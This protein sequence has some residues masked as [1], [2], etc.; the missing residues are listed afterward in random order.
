[1]IIDWVFFNFLSET[2]INKHIPVVII[3]QVSYSV[4]NLIGVTVNI[5]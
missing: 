1:M 2:E 5:Y 3:I 4:Y